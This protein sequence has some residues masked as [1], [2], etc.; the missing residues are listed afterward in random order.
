M[1]KFLKYLLAAI[2]PFLAMSCNKPAGGNG[3]GYFTLNRADIIGCWK[4][5][6]A[7][8]DEGATMTEWPNEDTYVIFLE[9]GQYHTEGYF[10]TKDGS[11]SIYTGSS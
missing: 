1:K 8:F 11:F 6:Q 7:K 10:G 9:N 2:I 5:I 3:D 4:V